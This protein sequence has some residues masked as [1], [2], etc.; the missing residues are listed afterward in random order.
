MKS[1]KT[2]CLQP[3]RSY[4]GH[5]CFVPAGN[6]YASDTNAREIWTPLG[7]TRTLRRETC[8]STVFTLTHLVCLVPS[9]Y[10]LRSSSKCCTRTDNRV[11]GAENIRSLVGDGI[12]RL[13]FCELIPFSAA[14]VSPQDRSWALAWHPWDKLPIVLSVLSPGAECSSL[15]T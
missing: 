6:R 11:M 5:K 15:A 4:N 2:V 8:T 13:T 1:N 10:D 9:V 12:L 3:H 7:A 14:P